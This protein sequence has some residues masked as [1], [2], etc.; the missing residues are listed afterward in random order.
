MSKSKLQKKY[1]I[2]KHNALNEFRPKDMTLQELRFFTIYLSKINPRDQ[3]TRVVRFSLVDFQ[4]I[5]EFTSRVHTSYLKN[6]ADGLLTKVTGIPDEKGKGMIRFQLFKECKIST[7]ENDEWFIEID[8]HDRALPLMFNFKGHYFKY[9]LWNALRLKSKN[10]LRMY[11]VLKQY[12]KIGSRI[13]AVEN[14]KNM[15]GIESNEYPQYKDFKRRVLDV[16]QKALA[17]YTDISYTYEPH[18]KKGRGGKIIEIKFTITKNKSYVDPLGL[19]K[20]IDLNDKMSMEHD[21]QDTNFDGADENGNLHS[22]GT[23]PIYEKR[24]AFLMDACNNEF[25]REQVVVLFDNMPSWVKQDENDSHDYL[26]SKYREMNMRRP[27]K[28]RFGYLKKLIADE[29]I[30]FPNS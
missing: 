7:D 2:T 26:Q 6:V 21:Y 10:Q 5:M 22:T 29:K 17:E 23:S 20:F 11:E 13:I 24:I 8:A 28:S 19:D 27:S 16:C 4:N 15:L 12:E 25:N 3:S 9:G 14:L 30:S 1:I 18:G